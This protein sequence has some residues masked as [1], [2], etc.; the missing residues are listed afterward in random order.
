MP[1]WPR[2][3]EAWRR[4]SRPRTSRR[5]PRHAAPG[6]HSASLAAT[7]PPPPAAAR[8]RARGAGDRGT[9]AAVVA[10]SPGIAQAPCQA[11]V[12]V[13]ALQLHLAVGP[14]PCGGDDGFQIAAGAQNGR[15]KLPPPRERFLAPRVVELPADRHRA[16]PQRPVDQ[17]RQQ[18]ALQTGDLPPRHLVAATQARPVGSKRVPPCQGPQA[19][20]WCTGVA[21]ALHE[22]L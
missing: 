8:G 16:Q 1:P 14:A 21:R 11:L 9:S 7:H 22:Q 18:S 4:A 3:A 13:A 2:L 20:W 17:V 19:S 5:P 10:R 12:A 15:S 6:A